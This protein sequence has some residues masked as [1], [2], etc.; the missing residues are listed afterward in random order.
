MDQVV[1]CLHTTQPYH[2][3]DDTT[4]EIVPEENSERGRHIVSRVSPSAPLSSE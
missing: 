2:E 3:D 1:L 4:V